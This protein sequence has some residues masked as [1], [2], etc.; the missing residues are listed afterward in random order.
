[1]YIGCCSYRCCCISTS[2]ISAFSQ[3]DDPKRPFSDSHKNS[4]TLKHISY[5][6][7]VGVFVGQAAGAVSAT[8]PTRRTPHV[9]TPAHR[10]CTN[11]CSGHIHAQPTRLGHDLVPFHRPEKTTK[12]L[13]RGLDGG[14]GKKR[15]VKKAKMAARTLPACARRAEAFVKT[16]KVLKH[17]VRGALCARRGTT[18]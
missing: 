7:Q 17:K 9:L 4:H 1:M 18:P 2:H 8:K 14:G 12:A 15:S 6:Y 16:I 10:A 3:T 11:R 13:D 5:W